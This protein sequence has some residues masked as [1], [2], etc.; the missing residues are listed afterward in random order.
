[1]SWL[2]LA[3]VIPIV[4]V[5]GEGSTFL[6]AFSLTGIGLLAYLLNTALIGFFISRRAPS[7]LEN[8]TW[9]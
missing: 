4:I 9:E 5:W 6:F 3:F 2:I 7:S 8:A 1:M